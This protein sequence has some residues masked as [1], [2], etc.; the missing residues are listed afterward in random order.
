MKFLTFRFNQGVAY[1]TLNSERSAI[2]LLSP[3]D[4]GNNPLISRFFKGIFKIRPMKP[5]YDTIRNSE[6]L[7]KWAEALEPLQSL[8]LKSHTMKLVSLLALATA[9]R[10]QTLSLV[11]INNIAISEGGLKIRITDQIKTTRV[12]ATQPCFNL[13][14]L[15]ER[16]GVCVA[17]VLK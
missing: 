11:K 5:K 3:V 14:F 9:H 7:L 17:R 15:N 1:G 12:G 4:L 2:N 16:K 13:P 8:D 6:T 10:V